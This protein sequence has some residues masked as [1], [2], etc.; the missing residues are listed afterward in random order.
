MPIVLPDP[1]KEGFGST[2]DRPLII[3][4]IMKGEE[5]SSPFFV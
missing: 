4:R 5:Y 3:G 1:I 2:T